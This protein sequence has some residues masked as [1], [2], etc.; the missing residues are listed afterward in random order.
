[1]GDWPV[2]RP[3]YPDAAA[4]AGGPLAAAA[5]ARLALKSYFPSNPL[6]FKILFPLKSSFY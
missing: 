1:M 4:A 6:F 3:G 2:G 5:A